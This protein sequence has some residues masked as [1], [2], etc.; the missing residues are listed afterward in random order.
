[1][2]EINTNPEA[3]EELDGK[4]L[5][6]QWANN[7]DPEDAID[8]WRTM[9]LADRAEWDRRAKPFTDVIRALAA[10]KRELSQHAAWKLGYASGIAAAKKGSAP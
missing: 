1:M 7:M 10:E 8:M 2:T 5:F 3:I 9:S 6:Y 4:T